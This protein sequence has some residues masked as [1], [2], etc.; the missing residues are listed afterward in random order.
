M[1]T[2]DSIL[3]AS[4]GTQG[5]QAAEHMAYGLC[6]SHTQLHHLIVVPDFWQGMMGDDW[7]NNAWTR[8]TFGDYVESQLQDEIN[9]HVE[10]MQK[11]ATEK[12]I[13]YHTEV[14][15]GKPTQCLLQAAQ[16]SR[17]SVIVIGSPRPKGQVGYRSRVHPEQLV[18][19][20]SMPLLI[21][22][23]PA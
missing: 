17:P 9:D 19:S 21:A 12:G 2:P 20:L 5:A 10:R 16:Q 13:D 15:L 23:F 7:L 22:P 3:L 14:V 18:K 11:Q 4:H 1:H 6:D 8:D